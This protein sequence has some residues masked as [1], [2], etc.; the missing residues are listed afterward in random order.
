[1]IVK[2][3]KLIPLFVHLSMRK[4]LHGAFVFL[5]ALLTFQVPL[6][7]QQVRLH[8]FDCLQRMHSS[9]WSQVACLVVAP[10]F[11][12]HHRPDLQPLH[13][14]QQV[15]PL[16]SQP[17]ASSHTTL[18][19]IPHLSRWAT[20]GMTRA[21]DAYLH[22]YSFV[23]WAPLMVVYRSIYWN[24]ASH[25]EI[26]SSL[27]GVEATHWNSFP[28]QCQRRIFKHLDRFLVG[29]HLCILLPLF[30]YWLY[31][32]LFYKSPNDHVREMLQ[33]M[34]SQQRI[35]YAPPSSSSSSSSEAIQTS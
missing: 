12:E 11:L 16:I 32:T 2:E 25:A 15:H 1:M 4:A 14:Q 30:V 21:L 17:H 3:S 13:A 28:D 26:C 7:F 29:A 20:L 5:V 31:H 19:S 33:L 27:T 18:L 23:A 10:S 8:Q 6:F 34:L 24:D 22:I 9:D 35:V